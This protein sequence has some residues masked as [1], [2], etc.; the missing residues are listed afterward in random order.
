M[1]LADTLKNK[2]TQIESNDFVGRFNLIQLLL[3]S[4]LCHGYRISCTLHQYKTAIIV[5]TVELRAVKY[6]FMISSS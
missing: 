4:K 3:N 5:H 2:T 1:F 6:S